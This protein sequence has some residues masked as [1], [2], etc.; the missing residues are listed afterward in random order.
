MRPSGFAL[1]QAAEKAIKINTAA[2]IRVR[3]NANKKNNSSTNIRPGDEKN[4]RRPLLGRENHFAGFHALN[5]CQGL[6]S[7]ASRPDGISTLLES[8][9]DDDPCAR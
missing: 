5:R 2:N 1:A 7:H 6:H 8:F 9:F 4:Q 3:R